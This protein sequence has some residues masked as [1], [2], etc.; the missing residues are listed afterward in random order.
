[1]K[2]KLPFTIII[3]DDDDD[4]REEM[5]SVFTRDKNFEVTNTFDSG[6]DAIKEIMVRKNIP[7]VLLIDMYMP[8]LTGTEIIKKLIESEAAPDMYKF[9]VSTTIN[10]AE[11]N[12]YRN[13]AKVKFINKPH[14]VEDIARLPEIIL[15]HIQNDTKNKE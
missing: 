7:N 12:K 11:Q 4:D 1:M 9:I 6:I 2:S 10:T 13:E 5:N 3:A 14:T 8:M 15:N